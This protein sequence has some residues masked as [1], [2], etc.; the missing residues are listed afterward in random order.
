MI[1][2]KNFILKKRPRTQTSARTVM[3][4]LTEATT[5]WFSTIFF[6]KKI[7]QKLDKDPKLF[8]IVS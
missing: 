1:C 4:A 6:L 8:F 7:I 2:N 5:E 3:A